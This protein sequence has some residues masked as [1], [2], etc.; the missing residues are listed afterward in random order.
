MV[1]ILYSR[2]KMKML[3]NSLLLL[4]SASLLSADGCWDAHEL[5]KYGQKT[6]DEIAVF[7]FR[8]AI[9]CEPLQGVHINFLGKEFVTNAEGTVEMP[10][11][12]DDIDAFVPMSMKKDKYIPVDQKLHVSVGNY[13][14]TLFLMTKEIPLNSARFV[15]TW[16][17]KPAD[18]DL[19]LK[20]E[21]FHISYRKT[22]SIPNKVKLDRD[23]RRGH[24]P[25]TITLDKLRTDKTYTL[26]VHQYSSDGNI[27]SKASVSV[28]L[29]NS[30]D[31]AL[32]LEK[33]DAKCIQ[34]A[35]IQN[36]QITYEIKEREE[37][38][39]K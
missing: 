2:K 9:T 1:I 6:L 15:L 18:L 37:S 21:D 10:Q 3:K 22:R 12:P 32:N 17:K 7:S 13:W 16:G 25:E 33:T 31:K 26:L 4:F 20:S 35:T 39:C 23:A 11:P 27:D 8:D 19:H 29:N 34:V 30:F 38:A 5:A 24:G 14:Q 28:Y 36:K